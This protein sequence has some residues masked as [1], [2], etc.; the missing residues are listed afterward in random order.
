V[1]LD[2][3]SAFVAAITC[4]SGYLMLVAGLRKGALEMRRRRR[5]CPSCGRT[6]RE[7]VC[8]VCKS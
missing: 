8:A 1:D 4:A 7:R 3:N 2:P 6:M 5:V